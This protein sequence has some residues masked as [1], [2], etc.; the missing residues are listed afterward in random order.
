MALNY[1]PGT[2]LRIEQVHLVI[3]EICDTDASIFVD[4]ENGQW[5]RGVLLLNRLT[6]F[7][8]YCSELYSNKL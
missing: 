4:E 1:L 8:S 3:P 6:T 5:D 7:V 2:E